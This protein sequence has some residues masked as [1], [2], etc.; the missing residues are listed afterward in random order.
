MVF[1]V[2]P[3]KKAIELFYLG[4]LLSDF[5]GIFFISKE[6]RRLKKLFFSSNKKVLS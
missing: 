3:N 2:P 1:S 4:I 5:G 6:K